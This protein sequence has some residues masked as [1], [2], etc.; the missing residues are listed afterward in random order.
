MAEERK[1]NEEDIG[2]SVGS[3][4]EYAFAVL[5]VRWVMSA[6]VVM[7]MECWKS[8]FSVKRKKKAWIVAF[9]CIIWWLR[10]EEREGY[11]RPRKQG[12]KLLC[13]VYYLGFVF[14]YNGSYCVSS[15]SFVVFSRRGQFWFWA[16]LS[17]CNWMCLSAPFDI[18]TRYIS[19]FKRYFG[20][21]SG[22]AISNV[23]CSSPLHWTGVGI[24]ACYWDG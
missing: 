2:M 1:R 24:G 7:L 3:I 16:V 14:L 15:Y 22:S 23:R 6:R 4:M 10:R 12:F 5:R 20:M 17:L 9:L 19:Y 21:C 8:W 11:F 13:C 18:F